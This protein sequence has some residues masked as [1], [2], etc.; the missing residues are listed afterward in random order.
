MIGSEGVALAVSAGL[1]G[2]FSAGLVSVAEAGAGDSAGDGELTGDGPGVATF[3]GFSGLLVSFS[4]LAF[5][6][7]G[8]TR[9]TRPDVGVGDAAG[10]ACDDVLRFGV[11][12][13]ATARVKAKVDT[14]A[15]ATSVLRILIDKNF[16]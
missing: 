3:G 4:A 7:A 10:F 11:V 5:S 16:R 8:L 1:S 12:F 14:I 2:F 13:C 6:V 9:R 15:R